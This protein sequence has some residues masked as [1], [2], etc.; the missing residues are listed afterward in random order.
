MGSG[1]GLFEQ[2]LAGSSSLWGRPPP[3]SRAL[4]DSCW[5]FYP[6]RTGCSSLSGQGQD[7]GASPETGFHQEL[8]RPLQGFE[9]WKTKP[10]HVSSQIPFANFHGRQAGNL[11]QGTGT[12]THPGPTLKPR[13]AGRA[14]SSTRESLRNS[15][16]PK[17]HMPLEVPPKPESLLC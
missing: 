17:T 11:V 1:G 15:L 14:G 9:M 8:A 2:N 13:R 4:A 6:K 16:D 3:P 5:A 10:D 7:P 12:H